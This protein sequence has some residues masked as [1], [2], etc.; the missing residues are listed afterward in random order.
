[1]HA[2]LIL[3]I[4]LV[5]DGGLGHGPSSLP[6]LLRGGVSPDFDACFP[7]PFRGHFSVICLSP[8]SN[9]AAA[10]AKSA[11]E[12]LIEKSGLD[13]RVLLPGMTPAGAAS[14]LTA[15]AAQKMFAG[16]ITEQYRGAIHQCLI[17]ILNSDS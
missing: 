17:I 2:F 3:Q 6:T 13:G 15:A 12:K 1:V 8:P 9:A 7:F 4:V 5:T 16:V 10:A 14:E 11:Y